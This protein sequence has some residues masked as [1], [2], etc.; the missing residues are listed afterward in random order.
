MTSALHV[1]IE[2][3][4]NAA[5]VV[6]LHGVTSSGKTWEWLPKE[7]TQGRR[8]VRLDFRGHG[9]SA[10]TPG[11]YRLGDYGAD[12]VSVLRELDRPAV[13]VGHSL[14]GVVAWWVAQNHP[15]FVVAALLEDP[16]LLAVEGSPEQ[17]ERAHDVFLNMKANVLKLRAAGLSDEQLADRIRSVPFASR[18]AIPFRE[19]AMDD[20]IR[21]IAFAHNRLDIGVLDGAIDRSTLA[22]TDVK[23]PVRPPI[24]ILAADDA[25]GAVFSTRDEKRLRETHPDVEVIRIAGSGHGIHDERRHRETFVR[26]LCAF[27]DQRAPRVEV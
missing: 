17:V 15:E 8:I 12:V 10:H 24:L 7:V 26:H 2:G 9:R 27:L 1:E 3:P 25:L 14:G 18:G 13:L 5:P 6:F 11:H 23:S 19:I 20:G 21:A 16:P 4:A 22:D